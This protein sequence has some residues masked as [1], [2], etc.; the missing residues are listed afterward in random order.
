MATII[1]QISKLDDETIAGIELNAVHL[2][3][4]H[5]RDMLRMHACVWL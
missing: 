3:K 2:L 1:C 5:L 4:S